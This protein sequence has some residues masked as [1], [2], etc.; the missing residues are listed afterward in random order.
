VSNAPRGLDEREVQLRRDAL[1]IFAAALEAVDPERLVRE[2]LEA[3]EPPVDADGK[4]TVV[5]VGKAATPMARGA[6]QVLGER[7][8]EGVVIT[9]ARGEVTPA[10]YRVYHGGHPFPNE[11]GLAGARHVEDIARRAHPGDR[12]ILLLSGGGSA[13]LTL[14]APDVSVDDLRRMAK[15]LMLAGA[16]IR[17]L[18]TVRKHVEVLKG[19]RL[20]ALAYPAEITALILSDVVGDPLD[21]IASGPVSPDPTTYADAIDVLE[22]HGVWREVADSIRQ[23][24]VR[25]S[26]QELGET[27]KPGDAA[28]QGVRARIVGSATLAAEAASRSAHA[29]GY[30]AEVASACV[31][32]EARRV[33]ETLARRAIALGKQGAKACTVY[34]GETTVT[35]RGNGR[36]GRS[37]ELA[38]AAATWLE[39]H[40]GVLVFSAGT[41]GV[42]GPTDAAGAFATGTTLARAKE[43]GL[44][45]EDH[46]ERSD[47]HPF[48]DRLHDLV[49]TGPTGTNVM[50]LML[51]MSAGPA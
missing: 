7:V 12:I 33:A 14:P 36:G 21:V 43:L 8:A 26:H 13:L 51:A 45:A 25:G 40:P 46:L 50:D 42:D 18:N 19:G 41:D 47:S 5:A 6:V 35:V 37:Q 1:T 11:E 30:E 27:P 23:H 44:D 28:L 17:E 24:L 48:F 2:A 9:P 31:T 10:A 49:R 38:L 3:N 15:M 29:L 39:G 20:A 16:D 34:A 4:L 32:G 22:R